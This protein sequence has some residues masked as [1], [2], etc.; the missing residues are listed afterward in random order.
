[1]KRTPAAAELEA[2]LTAQ[3]RVEAR[4]APAATAAP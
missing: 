2:E 4:A 1:M 3:V